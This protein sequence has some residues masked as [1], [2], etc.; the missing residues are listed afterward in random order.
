ML[1][2]MKAM[3]RISIFLCT[4]CPVEAQSWQN[5]GPEQRTFSVGLRQAVLFLSYPGFPATWAAV[6][7]WVYNRPLLVTAQDRGS[8]RQWAS[9]RV[10]AWRWVVCPYSPPCLLL[11]EYFGH[12]H[13]LLGTFEK[14][15]N[16]MMWLFLFFL[17]GYSCLLLPE[18]SRI[19][20]IGVVLKEHHTGA[21]LWQVSALPPFNPKG[22][23][24]LFPKRTGWT[25]SL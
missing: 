14:V 19:I 25:G 11:S 12:C 23:S 21:V 22:F 4:H 6:K 10:S 20:Q 2:W 24:L 18:L 5:C 16:F 1:S 7:C 13:V 3:V 8:A 9:G 17:W 15:N